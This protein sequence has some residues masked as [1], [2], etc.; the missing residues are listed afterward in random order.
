MREEERFLEETESQLNAFLGYGLNNSYRDIH[1]DGKYKDKNC[2]K[3]C[4]Q[5]S[6]GG[7]GGHEEADEGDAAE[8]GGEQGEQVK[9]QLRCRHLLWSNLCFQPRN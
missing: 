1:N 2:A 6:V 5:C 4:Q 7:E 8:V 9:K 3:V